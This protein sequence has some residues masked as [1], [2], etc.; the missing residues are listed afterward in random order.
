VTVPLTLGPGNPDQ[1]Y[2]P[3]ASA[4]GTKVYTAHVRLKRTPR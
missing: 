4:S 1:Q 2:T 3:A